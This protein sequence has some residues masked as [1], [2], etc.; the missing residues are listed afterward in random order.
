MDEEKME[1]TE[2][3]QDTPAAEDTATEQAEA[4]VVETAAPI[5]P[6]PEA[7]RLAAEK[8]ADE[9][10]MKTAIFIGIA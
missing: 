8:A 2:Q 5:A 10:A 4:A 1:V 3:V 6:D 7:E 9:E